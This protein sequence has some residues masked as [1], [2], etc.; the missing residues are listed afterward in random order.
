MT[1]STISSSKASFRYFD[2]NWLF[3]S[4][5]S[6]CFP[7]NDESFYGLI[8]YLNSNLVNRF[9]KVLSPTLD[10]HEGPVGRIPF[11]PI[12]SDVLDDLVQK[13]I[14]IA[15]NDWN[16]RENSLDFNNH[17]IIRF[18]GQDT[19]AGFST[20][21]EESYD[22]FQQFWKNKFFQLHKNEEELN[23]QFIDIYG[24]QGELTPDVPLEDITILKE[25]TD[26]VNCELVFDA[27]EVFTQFMSYAV[28]CMFGRYS[29]DKDGLILANQGETLKDYLIKVSKT[30]EEVSFLPDDDNIIPI[31]A[32]EWFTDDITGRFHE[33]LKVA[34]AEDQVSENLAFVVKCIGKDI[35]SYFLKGLY[36]DHIKRYKKRPI[37]W[38]FSSEKGAFNVL[39]YMHRYTSD[40]LNIILND[41][42][43]QFID[44][45]K[46]RV[47]QLEHIE[48][49]GEGKE[50]TRALKEMDKLQLQIKECETYE[51]EV[52]YPLASKRIE[53]DLDDGVL[54]NYNK[55]GKAV[56]DVSG[57]NDKKTKDKVRGFDWID[58]TEII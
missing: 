7:K 22:L 25:E 16:S 55:F 2:S 6:V 24:L 33:F 45:L 9:L 18:R 19:L 57:L 41:Y 52:L 56:K 46:N 14:E 26:I 11:I 48:R 28:G 38:M 36:D 50:K 39:I 34:F 53:I 49:T 32:D 35:R 29:L 37:Y 51:R 12:H 58:V 23:K 43:R 15:K 4:K 40:T 27:K 47:S 21:L 10:F 30:G 3:E 31:L 5:G 13:C 8:G 1:W 17:E 54:V 42:L 20:S 44:K